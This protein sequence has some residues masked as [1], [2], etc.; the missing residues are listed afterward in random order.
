[1]DWCFMFELLKPRGFSDKWIR[2]IN[3]IL[4]SSK[5]KF[6]ITGSQSGYVKYRKGVRQGDPLSPSFSFS[7]LMFLEPCSTMLL[8]LEFSMEWQLVILESK[9][10]NYNTRMT[11]LSLPQEEEAKHVFNFL[12]FS[13]LIWVD[14]ARYKYGSFNFW[15]DPIPTTCS[16][17]F[18]VVCHTAS[19][20]KHWIWVKSIN[21]H[22]TSF[23]FDPWYYDIPIALKPTF[24][25]MNL[26]L[27]SFN[28]VNVLVE[29]C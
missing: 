18:C 11:F 3:A 7:G 28:L 21:P 16:S 8:S 25:D 5:V 13:N 24:I 29:F 19:S 4:T 12:N 1:M 15:M 22:T 27:E 6:L 9:C 10:I 20:I 2:W 26:A 14:I 23:M 17:F